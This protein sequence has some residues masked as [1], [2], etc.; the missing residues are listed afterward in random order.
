MSLKS[1]LKTSAKDIGRLVFTRWPARSL[2]PVRQCESEIRIG[3]AVVRIES[4]QGQRVRIVVE[5]PTSVPVFR[6]ELKVVRDTAEGGV[7]L[8]DAPVP[9]A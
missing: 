4:F 8:V 6:G 5:A 7:P 2:P 3:D 1:Q 9:A